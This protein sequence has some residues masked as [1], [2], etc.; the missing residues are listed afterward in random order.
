MLIKK[1]LNLKALLQLN[2]DEQEIMN[3][4]KDYIDSVLIFNQKYLSGQAS[5]FD[6]NQPNLKLKINKVTDIE[7]QILA[8]NYGL[9]GMFV[10]TLM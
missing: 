4:I 9:K 5:L 10:F 8:P 1:P 2:L 6:Q 3:E 7:D